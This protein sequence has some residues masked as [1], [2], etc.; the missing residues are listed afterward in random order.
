MANTVIIKGD[1]AVVREDRPVLDNTARGKLIRKKKITT[2]AKEVCGNLEQ[3]QFNLQRLNMKLTRGMPL[4]AADQARQTA[5]D[6][7]LAFIDQV[8][9]RRD[10]LIAAL[11][12]G[13]PIKI[14]EGQIAGA[15]AW[16]TKP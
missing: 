2:K 15:G 1:G 16:P 12:A 7:Q 9:T 13:Q 10:E 11:D 8:N 14:R 4:S 6:A 3:M 5:I